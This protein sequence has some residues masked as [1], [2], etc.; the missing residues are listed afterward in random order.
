MKLLVNIKRKIIKYKNGEKVTNLE[1][2]EVH[3]ITFFYS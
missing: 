2:T 1:I 3:S